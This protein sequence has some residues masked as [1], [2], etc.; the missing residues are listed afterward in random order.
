[1]NCPVKSCTWNMQGRCLDDREVE[2]CETAQWEIQREAE[3]AG[4][5]G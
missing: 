4:G 1:M 3:A 2:D 5:E